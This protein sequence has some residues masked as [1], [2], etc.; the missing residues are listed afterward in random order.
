LYFFRY[1]A[2]A[3]CTLLF[4]PRRVG[5]G[6]CDYVFCRDCLQ[7][8]HLGPCLPCG[9]LAAPEEGGGVTAVTA[10]DPRAARATWL[11]ADPSSVT[12]RVIS[13]PCPN[14]RSVHLVPSLQCC[15]SESGSS[16]S[17]C[18]WASWIRIRIHL[19]EVWIRIRIL[20]S[21]SQ[22]SKKTLISTV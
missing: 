7:G 5:C 13:K 15:G 21:L 10:G 20:L 6:E 14:C 8:A 16:G 19:S 4:I 12:I 17:T 22:N 2:R 9:G 18:F 3:H 11:G 1:E